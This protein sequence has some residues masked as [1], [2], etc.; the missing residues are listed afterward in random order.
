MI[1]SGAILIKD[2]T[3]LPE[4]LGLEIEFSA[5]GWAPFTND[6]SGRQL[7]ESLNTAG[8]TFFYIAGAIRTTAFGFDRARSVHKALKRLISK[9]RLQ[10][11]NCLEIDAVADHSFLSV[12]YVSVSAHSRHIQKG[13]IFDSH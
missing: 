12:P 13:L 3:L 11:C 1:K 2:G 5:S 7:K 6:F 10:N 4:L 8:W 9:V